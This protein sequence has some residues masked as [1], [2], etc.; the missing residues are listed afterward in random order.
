MSNPHPLD[1][2]TGQPQQ[3]PSRTGR[4]RWNLVARYS[5]RLTVIAFTLS[6]AVWLLLV[7]SQWRRGAATLERGTDDAVA[8]VPSVVQM[9]D[10]LGG[11]WMFA[12]S[13]WSV[14]ITKVEN[15]QLESHMAA[16][17]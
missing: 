7:L 2:Q 13:P 16:A 14:G 3:Q 6:A 9:N 10:L 4:V 5:A 12:A 1:A 11:Q 17:P 15:A 8:A